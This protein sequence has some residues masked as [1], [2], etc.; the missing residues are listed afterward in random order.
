MSDNITINTNKL[1]AM[2]AG[3]VFATGAAGAGAGA[4]LGIKLAT[5]VIGAGAAG[6]SEAERVALKAE[7]EAFRAEVRD[8]LTVLKEAGRGGPTIEDIS[9]GIQ[10]AFAAMDARSRD[11]NRKDAEAGEAYLKS[12]SKGGSK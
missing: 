10:R 9:Q 1:F 4:A 5:P 2:I 11:K 3:L 6:P 7:R 8:T 12:L